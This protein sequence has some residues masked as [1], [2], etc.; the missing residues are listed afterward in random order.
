M[1]M[2]AIILGSTLLATSPA[3][4]VPAADD[5]L[6]GPMAIQLRN[7]VGR[8]CVEAHLQLTPRARPV[9]IHAVAESRLIGG[10]WLLTEMRG[11]GFAGVGLNGFDSARRRYTGYWAD[12]SRGFAV[13]VEGEYDAGARAFR[14][15]ST[16]RRADGASVT[17][18]SETRT[19]G[20]D[21][22]V[23]TFT[24]PDAEGRPYQR[25]VMRYTRAREGADCPA[26]AAP[27]R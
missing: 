21:E 14:T 5:A 25:M 1:R 4:A 9:E 19:T 27:M 15:I 11:P 8:W 12:G 24:A 13:P 3:Q 10:R 26:G 7:R 2:K 22:E 20:A 18:H 16:E 6:L 17:V 23:T